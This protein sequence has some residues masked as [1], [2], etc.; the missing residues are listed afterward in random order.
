MWAKWLRTKKQAAALKLK[1]SEQDEQVELYAEIKT[2]KQEWDNAYRY[3]DNALG[4][5]Q[6]DYAIFAIGAAEKRYEMLIRK[7]KRLPVEWSALKG[8]LSG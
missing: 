5:D 4:K 3:F 1:K 2:A 7:A 8:G 6:I